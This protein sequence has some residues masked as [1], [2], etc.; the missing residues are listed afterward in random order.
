[1]LQICRAE[2]GEVTQVRTVD[3]LFGRAAL[4]ARACVGERNAARYRK[5]D[6]TYTLMPNLLTRYKDGKL[7]I[8][9]AS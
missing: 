8:V 2:D 3:K 6:S 1:M 9:S 7:G 5:V 4:T